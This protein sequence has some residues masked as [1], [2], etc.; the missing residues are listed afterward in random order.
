MYNYARDLVLENRLEEAL[1][2]SAL[3]R[4][5]CIRQG[6][7]CNLPGFLHIDAGCYY[8]MGEF[9]KSEELCRSSYYIYGAIM[10]TRDQE[11][12]KTVAEKHFNLI[13]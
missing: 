4:Q 9:S 11:I 13:F 7:Y 1:E 10:D 3:G 6:N 8:L 5:V 2:I 12:L